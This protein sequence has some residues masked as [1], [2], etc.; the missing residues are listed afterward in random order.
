MNGKHSQSLTTEKADVI[1]LSRQRIPTKIEM[2]VG[3]G[4]IVISDAVKHL[5][6]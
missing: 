4:T 1:L 3:R 5:G 2:M 6:L